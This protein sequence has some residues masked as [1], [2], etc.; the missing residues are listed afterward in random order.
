MAWNDLNIAQ[1]S[2]LM[3][4]M[5]RNGIESLSQMRQTYDALSFS[6]QRPDPYLQNQKAPMYA[7]GGDKPALRMSIDKYALLYNP[8]VQSVPDV[9][10][11]LRHEPQP[12]YG[13]YEYPTSTGMLEDYPI[14]TR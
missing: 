7:G 12:H 9:R 11:P 13:Q 14:P 6:P 10:T 2:Q 1:R 8:P 5:R 3:N 4:I